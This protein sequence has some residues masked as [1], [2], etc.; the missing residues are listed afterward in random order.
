MATRRGSKAPVE[1][2]PAPQ[3]LGEAQ[4]AY[5]RQLPED[6]KQAAQAE[7]ARFVRWLG[8]ERGLGSIGPPEIGEYSDLISAKGTTPDAAERLGTVKIFLAHLKPSRDKWL[9]AHPVRR[10]VDAE[11]S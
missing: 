10:R 9:A 11:P 7:I 1:E 8:P 2:E 4:Y 3:E 5:V 6:Q